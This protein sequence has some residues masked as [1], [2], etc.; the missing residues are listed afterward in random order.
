M[1]ALSTTAA[2]VQIQKLSFQKFRHF[3]RNPLPK[4]SLIFLAINCNFNTCLWPTQT[5][6]SQGQVFNGALFVTDCLSW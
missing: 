5:D 1:F 4:Q 6:T 2:L 3:F